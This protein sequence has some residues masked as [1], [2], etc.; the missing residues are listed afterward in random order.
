[1]IDIISIGTDLDIADSVAPRAA[2]ILSVQT[3]SLYYARELGIDLAYFLRPD[4][5][6][7]NSS[8]RAYLVQRLATFSIN[9]AS[10]DELIQDLNSVLGFNLVADETNGSLIAR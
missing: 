1:M 9:V 3:N 6:F 10:V 7:Q 2:N 5:E 8:F 4:V